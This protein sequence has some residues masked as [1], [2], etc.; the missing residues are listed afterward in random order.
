MEITYDYNKVMYEEKNKKWLWM[1][2]N[3]EKEVK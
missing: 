1:N 2:A 3:G